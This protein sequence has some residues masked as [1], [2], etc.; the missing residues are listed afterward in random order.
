VTLAIRAKQA[1]RDL[2]VIRICACLTWV[3]RVP[4]VRL[5]K[6][7]FLL[8][9]RVRAAHRYC[10]MGRSS[11]PAR[12]GSWDFACDAKG[13][14]A[15]TPPISIKRAG[16]APAR[17]ANARRVPFMH[18]RKARPVVRRIVPEAVAASALR[19]DPCN[20]VTIPTQDRQADGVRPCDEAKP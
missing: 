4:P 10:K 8:S 2:R 16:S 20:L 19:P 11:A 1:P 13:K 17:G 18:C 9:A 7:W 3:V 14:K 5:M 6:F 12:Q 15:E